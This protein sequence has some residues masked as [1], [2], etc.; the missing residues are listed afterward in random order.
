VKEN[1]FWGIGE[2]VGKPTSD[3]D[4]DGQKKKN[5]RRGFEKGE[6]GVCA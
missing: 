1:F 2:N 3:A 5:K 6:A 4:S